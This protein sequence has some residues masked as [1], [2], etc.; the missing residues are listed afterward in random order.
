MVIR[1]LLT[2]AERTWLRHRLK[3]LQGRMVR[4]PI[5]DQIMTEIQAEADKTHELVQELR[6]QY[7]RSLAEEPDDSSGTGEGI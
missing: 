2:P 6:S 3:E 4:L 7:K 1:K 5:P